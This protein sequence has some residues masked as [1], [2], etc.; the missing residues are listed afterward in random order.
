ME[1]PNYQSVP[2]LCELSVDDVRKVNSLV[3]S[4]RWT[5]GTQN[6]LVDQMHAEGRLAV[7]WTIDQPPWIRDFINE[8]HFDGLLTNF[9]YVVAY[10][11]YIR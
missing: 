1:Y 3:W 7:T 6:D 10:Y 8:G 2:S 4:P 9:P 5:L 11:H